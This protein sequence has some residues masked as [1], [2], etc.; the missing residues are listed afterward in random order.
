MAEAH[1][2]QT[3]YV[4]ERRGPGRGFGFPL[5]LR[6]RICLERSFWIV[7]LEMELTILFTTSTGRL[8]PLIMQG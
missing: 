4:D 3:E 6:K 2:K 7:D 8:P 1:S 5:I